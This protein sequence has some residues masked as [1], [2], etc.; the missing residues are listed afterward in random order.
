MKETICFNAL[1]KIAAVACLLSCS[2]L[3]EDRIPWTSSGFE[4]TPDPPLPYGTEHIFPL[5]KFKNPVSIIH[6]S[7]WNRYFVLEVDGRLFSFSDQGEGKVELVIDLKEAIPDVQKGYGIVFDPNFE[8][9]RFLYLC[10]A[11]QNKKPEGTVVAR[12]KMPDTDRPS[13]NLDSKLELIHWLSGGHNGGCLK[14]GPDGYLYISTG[15]AEAPSPPDRLQTGQDLSD[16]LAGI[17]RID[18]AHSSQVEPYR[19]PPDNPFVGFE[20]V[21]EEIWAYGMRNPWRMSFDR[22]DGDLWVGDVGWELWEMI[23]RV[24]RGGNYG[25]SVVEGRQP[26]NQDAKRGPTPILLPTAEHPHSEARSITGGFVYR[27][28]RLPGLKGRYLYGDY[29]SGKMWGLLADAA[30]LS[31]PV[32]ISNTN[33]QIIAFGEDRD[34]DLLIL[35]YVNG[36]I[37]RLIPN[38]QLDN[39]K[40]F[41]HRLSESGLFANLSTHQLALG[42]DAYQINAAPWED[43]TQ[44]NR[45]VAIPNGEQLGRYRRNRFQQGELRNAWSFPEGSILG[46]TI[47]LPSSSQAD[48]SARLIETQI[49]HRLDGRWNAYTYV[50]DEDQ[51][52]AVL[53]P[54]AGQT[55]SLATDDPGNI[56][57]IKSRDYSVPSRTECIL[58]HT[59]QAG[60]VLGFNERQLKNSEATKSQLTELIAKNYFLHRPRSREKIFVDPYDSSQDLH[61]RARSYLHVNCAHCHRFGGGGTAIFDVR[62]ELSNTDTKLFASLPIQGTFGI[63]GGQVIAPGDPSSSLLFYRMAKLGQGRMPHFGSKHVD[64][65][66]LQLLSDWIHSLPASYSV[67]TNNTAVLDELRTQQAVAQ[68]QFR[69]ANDPST[70]TAEAGLMSLLSTPSGAISLLQQA[71]SIRPQLPSPHRDAVIA[72]GAQ[73]E[74]ARVRDLFIHFIPEEERTPRLGLD[75]DPLP[76]LTLRGDPAAGESLLQNDQSLRCL[77]CHQLNGQGREVG[78]A[79][80]HLASRLPREEILQ[81]LLAPSE[82]IAPEYAAKLLETHNG[83]IYSGFIVEETEETLHFRDVNQGLI[84]VP[85][86]AIQSRESQS[87]S[88]MPQ[89]LLQGL[90]PQQAADLLAFL[91]SLK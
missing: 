63:E 86:K 83:D 67:L 12:F 18:I 6:S 4:G 80:D 70:A 42:V 29:V 35:D 38:P 69:R 22:E 23:Y 54:S 48:D 21:R 36:T 47:S 90:T 50:W 5:A 37:H 61:Q 15:D 13:I 27:G 7:E 33:I 31:S 17:L 71:S 30:P 2:M 82:K 66:G 26:V 52:D 59:T 9:N 60:S 57:S 74:D 56:S 8:A 11:Y 32:E 28:N 87:L 79:L 44:A 10:Y 77:E 34:G 84:E 73:H 41:P 3:A 39:P 53:A 40:P 14:F 91:T 88:L 68:S 81:S 16:L 58:C 64:S 51:H 46:K 75:T 49:L 72:A 65:K 43:Q 24:E 1:R 78:P 89:Y 45:F 62:Y 55:L 20:N 85:M 25:W 76:I 19:I